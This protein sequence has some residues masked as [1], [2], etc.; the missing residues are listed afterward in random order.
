MPRSA[1]LSGT[2]IVVV[3]DYPDTLCESAES[4][5]RSRA[6]LRGARSP[7]AVATELPDNITELDIAE[8]ARKLYEIAL[9]ADSFANIVA[10]AMTQPE[11]VD[12]NEILF[13]PTRQEL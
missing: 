6:P 9:P 1:I 2:T 5:A 7:G 4:L 12:I 8:N 11:E 13:R 3:E 10:F